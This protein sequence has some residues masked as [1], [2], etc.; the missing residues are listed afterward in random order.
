MRLTSIAPAFPPVLRRVAIVMGAM[1]LG[2]LLYTSFMTWLLHSPQP[3]GWVWI[4]GGMQWSDFLTFQQRSAHFRTST[5]WLEYDYPMTYPAP[6][7]VIFGLFYKLAYPLKIYLAILAAAL[8]A[9][10]LWMARGLARRGIPF[11]QATAF[12]LIVVV[13][14]WP[15]YYQFDVANI[16]GLMAIILVFGILAVLRGWYWTGSVLISIA[17]AM[18]LYPAI[19]LGLLFSK[20]RYK[21]FAAGAAL[22][23]ILNYAS[24]AILG[25]SISVAQSQLRDGFR[26]LRNN[27]IT[28]RQAFQ[29]NFSHALYLPMKFGVLLIDRLIRYGGKHGPVPHEIA[30]VDTTLGIYM[31]AMALL[32]LTLYFWRI[33]KLPPTGRGTC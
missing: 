27:F 17:G 19:M 3:F 25:P 11:D 5:Y 6:V 22:M 4:G 18:K 29:L 16:E 26:F 14:S 30:V 10:V 12:G 7:A 2:S 20:R 31:V 21:Q 28:P 24:L 15:I 33:R 23:V 8:I 1:L 9:F 32:G 13:T